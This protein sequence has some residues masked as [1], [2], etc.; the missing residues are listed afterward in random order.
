MS[1]KYC[2]LSKE[3]IEGVGGLENISY[4]TH[5]ATRLRFKLKNI[6]KAN[7]ENLKKNNG[8]IT[9]VESGGQYQVVIGN[10]VS[11]VYNQLVKGT[12]LETQVDNIEDKEKA[13]E[14]LI[15]RFISAISAIFSPLMM[16]LSGAGMLKA[17]LILGNTVGVL[18]ENSGAYMILYAAADAIFNFLPIALAFTSAK[19]FKA[20]QFL[21][22]IIGASLV[23]PNIVA[24]YNEGQSINFLGLPVILVS[25]TSSVIPA[26]ISVWALAK[27][28][29]FLNK[30]I[31]SILKSFLVPLL[32]ISIIVPLTYLTIGPV[33]SYAG[34]YLADG[35]K[36][37]MSI[38][39]IIAGGLVSVIWPTVIIFGLHW[40]FVPIV[41]NNI[42]T[43]G[44]D[45]LFVI[46][47]PN[48]FSQ[49][50]ACLGVFLKTK[51]KDLKSIAGPA[52]VSA[53]LTG[54]TE[55]A[56]YGVNLKFKKPFIIA[57]IFSGV[58]GAIT[59]AAGTGVG[60]FIG[61]SLIT[62]PAYIGVGFIGFL[63]ACAIAYVGS[64]VTTFIWGF[65]DNMILEG[66]TDK[67]VLDS[68]K[69]S[70][71]LKS[72]L[73]GELVP[74]KD[75]P[76]QCFSE[77]AMGQGIAIKPYKGELYAPADGE[78]KFVF[79]TKHALGF[80]TNEGVEIL[81]HIGIDTVELEGKYYEMHI[82]AGDKVKAGDLLVTFDIEKISEAGYSTITPIIVTN[83]SEFQD[84][85]ISTNDK[86]LMIESDLLT[87]VI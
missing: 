28:E 20:N 69:D 10:H 66:L 33:T 71:V 18:Q 23:Y 64:A 17:L 38:N 52:A 63:I 79:P 51:D 77:G 1:T 57:S 81:M 47:G 85:I 49:A 86:E 43:Y 8:V 9:V 30:I 25:Y 76:D 22:F 7:T 48:N 31:P 24:L 83:S 13:K 46:T 78:V 21:A 75:I 60:A 36:W 12:I 54:I 15:D 55:P 74:L 50:G 67:S 35:Y 61:T 41:L 40:G 26:I 34:V 72:A 87:V 32:C 45:T 39:P 53:V 59:A 2:D 82:N 11:E 70:V 73:Q 37:V 62:L 6:G 42:A 5:C 16:A 80:E 65:N 29:A 27:V 19:Y 56:I 4:V 68:K 84:I 44:R 14:K 58:A 3:I